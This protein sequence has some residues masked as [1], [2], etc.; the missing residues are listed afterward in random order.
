MYYVD[1]V[2]KISI[3][4][5]TL[6][7]LL[8]VGCRKVQEEPV[9]EKELVET[10]TDMPQLITVTAGDIKVAEYYDGEIN[11]AMQVLQFPRKGNF[12]EYKVMLGDTVKKGQVVAVTKPE[13]EQEIEDLSEQLEELRNDYNN[14][15][16]SYDLQFA[17]N[18]WQAGQFRKIIESMTPDMKGFDDICISYELFLAEGEKIKV[19]KKQYMERTEKE[20][21]FQEAKLARLEAKNESNI[22]VAPQDG[23]ITYLADLKV[24]DPVGVNSYPIVLADTKR[25]LVQCE[26]ISA[27]D[28]EDVKIVYGVKDGKEYE[29]KYLPDEKGADT[30]TFFEVVS[31]DESICFGED[32][33]VIMVTESKENVLILPSGCIRN[34][35]GEDYVYCDV[36]GEKEAVTIEI[37]MSD[38]INTEI[39]S[40]LAEGDIVYASN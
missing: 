20:I 6:V 37:G 9:P 19:E 15:V 10:T 39:L 40:G 3:I 32:I 2:K 26:Y 21:A 16:T 5:L 38:E 31:P 7:L 13:C 18:G 35:S 25:S 22:I 1:R 24:G 4:A 30:Y 27:P 33:K 36:N 29:M 34:D 17:T 23:I 12:L 11:P 14:H 28:M 8:V